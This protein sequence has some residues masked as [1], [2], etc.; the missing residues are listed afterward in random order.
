MVSRVG[1]EMEQEENFSIDWIGN[2]IVSQ[3]ILLSTINATF[4]SKSRAKK[5][6]RRKEKL[7]I[8]ENAFQPL[9]NYFM[10]ELEGNEL[11]G[12]I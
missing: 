4:F 9:S 10:V 8:V 2:Q 6:E 11:A 3:A 5:T 7:P 1:S 12:A